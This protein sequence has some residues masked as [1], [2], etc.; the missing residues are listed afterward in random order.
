MQV[1]DPASPEWEDPKKK[2][3]EEEEKAFSIKLST[4]DLQVFPALR[5]INNFPLHVSQVRLKGDAAKEFVVEKNAE[6][7]KVKLVM[8]KNDKIENKEKEEEGVPS[9]CPKK[10]CPKRHGGAGSKA[11]RQEKRKNT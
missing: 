4:P 10:A 11:R 9:P 1:Y 6:G 3:S 7:T 8:K 5:W 2:K